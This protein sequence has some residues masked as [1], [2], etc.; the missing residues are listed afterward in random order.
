L[1]LDCTFKTFFHCQ[2]EHYLNYF[3]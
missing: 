2:Y 3:Y 1:H